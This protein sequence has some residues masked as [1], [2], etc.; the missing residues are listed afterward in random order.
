MISPRHGHLA[1]PIPGQG[2]LL[3]GGN[4]GYWAPTYRQAPVEPFEF[5]DLATGTW[6][7]VAAINELPTS[8]ANYYSATPLADGTVLLIGDVE[9]KR[10]V[11]LRY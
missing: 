4:L 8:A 5:F 3:V 6:K 10:A 2:L 11:Q 7:E 9:G 1:V